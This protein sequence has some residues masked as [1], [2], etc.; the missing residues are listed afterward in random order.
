MTC[1]HE[2]F[3]IFLIYKTIIK[4]KKREKLDSISI[5]TQILIIQ[6]KKD[7]INPKGQGISTFTRKATAM[8][9][10]MESIKIKNKENE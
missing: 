6:I 10:F 8:F 2:I 3:L 7:Q 9:G 1:I 4:N 5:K